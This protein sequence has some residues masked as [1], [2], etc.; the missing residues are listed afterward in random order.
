MASWSC[1]LIRFMYQ[2]LRPSE[3]WRKRKCR[4]CR[5]RRNRAGGVCAQKSGS[6]PRSEQF[7]T[8]SEFTKR[9]RRIISRG[10]RVEWAP[11]R[12]R[13]CVAAGLSTDRC[14]GRADRRCACNSSSR[15]R[16]L[17]GR[18]WNCD[19]RFNG[20]GLA[21]RNRLQTSPPAGVGAV[22]QFSNSGAKSS[23]RCGVGEHVAGAGDVRLSNR[24][25]VC[26][27]RYLDMYGLLPDAVRPGRTLEEILDCRIAAGHFFPEERE[28]YIAAIRT[29]GAKK[30]AFSKLTN[31][32]DGR[33][34]QIVNRPVE[35][36]GSVATHEDVTEKMRRENPSVCSLSPI[37]CRCGLWIGKVF[38]FL[39]STR[40][41]PNTT[42]IV[43]SNLCR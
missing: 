39:P 21:P 26:N 34:I 33:F 8:I 3:P 41:L 25:V 31:L 5:S 4:P 40:L 6:W 23:T 17:P 20:A 14:R 19:N 2:I 29:A 10:G 37:P 7:G 24:L 16:R 35:H 15:E 12:I 43:A 22:F 18:W 30:I 28:Q 38:A 1:P 11:T 9:E 13:V 42:A 36:G 27:R 32:P